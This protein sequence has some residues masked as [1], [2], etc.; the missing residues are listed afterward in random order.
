MTEHAASDNAENEQAWAQHQQRSAELAADAE[1]RGDVVVAIGGGT[2]TYGSAEAREPGQLATIPKTAKQ[3]FDGFQVVAG[4]IGVDLDDFDALEEARLCATSLPKWSTAG[5][6]S[7]SSRALGPYARPLR[8][9][10][11]RVYAAARSCGP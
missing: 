7:G 9:C 4:R 8:S 10:I 1:Q 3:Y 2:C 6:A 11:H 5:H